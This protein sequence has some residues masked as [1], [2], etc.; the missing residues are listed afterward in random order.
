[1][2][3]SS[4]AFRR[5]L[6]AWY[7]K[8]GRDLP[9]RDTRDPY[10]ILVSEIMLQQT[11][12]ATVIPY[13][14]RWLQRFPGF[15]ALAAASESDVLHAWQGLGYYARARNFHALARA[16]TNFPTVVEEMRRLPGIGRYTANAVATFAFDQSVPV[17][18]A[19]IARLISRLTNLQTPI[20]SA[21]GCESLWSSAAALVPKRNARQFNSA[22]MDLGAM[23]C[24][25]RQPKCGICPVQKFCTAKNPAELPRKRPR[26]ALKILTERHAFTR[27][28]NRILLEQATHRWRGMWIL[29]RLPNESK[30]APIHLAEFPFTNHRIT[31]AVHARK[32]SGGRWFTLRALE[33][34]PIPSPHRRALTHL[35]ARRHSAT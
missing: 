26:A 1:M 27:K 14:N 2:L 18:E 11:Q 28:H 34:I 33:K 29:P 16:V 12:V 35:L 32:S 8:H 13:Y 5:A 3:A 17:V 19:N 23:I 20:D 6:L 25:A 7:G 9:W 10:A 22:L 24:T 30:D 31:L 4:A 15:P 21:I